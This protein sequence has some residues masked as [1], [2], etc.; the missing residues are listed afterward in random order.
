[1][2]EDCVALLPQHKELIRASGIVA[3]VAE[4]RGYRSVQ[5]KADLR[6]LGFGDAQLRTPA[7][8]IPIRNVHGDISLYQIRPDQPRIRRGKALK[9]ETT[10]GARMVLDVHPFIKQKMGDPEIPLFITEG[11]RK[12]DA[13][14]S[15]GLAWDTCRGTIAGVGPF[16]WGGRS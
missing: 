3:E 8:L 10:H 9:Y 5:S 15:L 7:L 1:M 16:G 4:A 2:T 13:S 14:I 11:A 12:A 6:R